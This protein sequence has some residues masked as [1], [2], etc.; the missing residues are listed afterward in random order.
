MDRKVP[1]EEK[2]GL[3]PISAEALLDENPDEAS[4]RQRICRRGFRSEKI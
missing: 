4:F 3:H 2:W 1:M